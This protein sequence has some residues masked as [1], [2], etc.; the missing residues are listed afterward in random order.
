M[1]GS[2]D[3]WTGVHGEWAN[4]VW[5]GRHSAWIILIAPTR[6]FAKEFRNISLGMAMK[7]RPSPEPA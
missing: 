4:L 7:H 5:R 6:P 2:D 1:V 3:E